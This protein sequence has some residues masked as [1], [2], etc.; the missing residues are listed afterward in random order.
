MSCSKIQKCVTIIDHQQVDSTI[1]CIVD[2][3]DVATK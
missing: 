2:T 1:I 3:V